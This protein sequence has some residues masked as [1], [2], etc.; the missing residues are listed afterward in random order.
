[1]NQVDVVSNAI[2]TAG[3]GIPTGAMV[4]GADI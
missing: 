3:T 4:L 1:M 2:V